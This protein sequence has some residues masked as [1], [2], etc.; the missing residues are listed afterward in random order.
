MNKYIKEKLSSDNDLINH[1]V[2]IY[3][4]GLLKYDNSNH[5]GNLSSGLTDMNRVLKI[6]KRLAA[7]EFVWFSSLNKD[8]LEVANNMRFYET[9]NRHL[10]QDLTLNNNDKSFLNRIALRF[11]LYFKFYYTKAKK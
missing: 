4:D 11:R 2:M 3:T 10:A 9:I 8:A 5:V 1:L 7:V 6:F